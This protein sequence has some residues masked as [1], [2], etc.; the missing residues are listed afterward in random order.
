MRVPGAECG[1]GQRR[2]AACGVELTSGTAP[3]HPTVASPP[4]MRG[5]WSP[6]LPPCR[7]RTSGRP[8]DQ[9]RA[10]PFTMPLY[11]TP[12]GPAPP[13]VRAARPG[14]ATVRSGRSVGFGIG[15]GLVADRRSPPAPAVAR[16][17]RA[18]R[19]C[20][21]AETRH[22][23]RGRWRRQPCRASGPTSTRRAR[24]NQPGVPGGVHASLV[25]VD[26]AGVAEVEPGPL[27]PAGE[28]L[29]QVSLLAAAPGVRPAEADFARSGGVG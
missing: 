9:E 27:G 6:S 11:C 5:I 28:V 22:S 23:C 3:S 24:R 14:P 29:V 12:R 17:A 10:S 2:T 4:T 19:R 1:V 15:V 25:Q 26:A 8:T 7:P 21:A 16:T 13:V 18:S 20:C